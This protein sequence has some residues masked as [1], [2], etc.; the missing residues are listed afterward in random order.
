MDNGVMSCGQQVEGPL[1]HLPKGAAVMQHMGVL[2]NEEV[3]ALWGYQSRVPES[4]VCDLQG[5]LCGGHGWWV[6]AARAS[7]RAMV[8]AVLGGVSWSQAVTCQAVL[9]LGLVPAADCS[10]DGFSLGLPCWQITDPVKLWDV[11]AWGVGSWPRA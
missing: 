4:A 11:E 5:A 7:G 9:R 3:K 6:E 1:Y 2:N 10:V 8:C